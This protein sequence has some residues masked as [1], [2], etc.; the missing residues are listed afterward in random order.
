[1]PFFCPDCR[2]WYPDTSVTCEQCGFNF[3][4]HQG[5]PSP[6]SVD[7]L[8][9]RETTP[10]G[11]RTTGTAK[12]PGPMFWPIHVYILMSIGIAISGWANAGFAV[13]LSALGTS[14]L[15][16]SAGGGLKA[17]LWWGDQTQK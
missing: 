7:E 4:Q 15:A 14:G 2:L 16:L 17:S 9:A 8:L 6:V 5:A 11:P 3:R 13:G 10:A 12:W 1:M